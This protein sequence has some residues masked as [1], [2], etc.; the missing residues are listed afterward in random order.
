M[1]PRVHVGD[2]ETDAGETIVR[3]DDVGHPIRETIE[4]ID[5][6]FAR[7]DPERRGELDGDAAD[8]E[9]L[10]AQPP[11]FEGLVEREA[12]AELVAEEP[13]RGVGIAGEDD[14]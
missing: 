14:R 7:C 12:Q 6:G 10:E 5:G 3:G 2:V 9:E 4:A 8:A 11:L 1:H 13:L